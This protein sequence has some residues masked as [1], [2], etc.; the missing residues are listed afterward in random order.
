MMNKSIRT[1][2]LVAIACSFGFFSG[3]SC[4]ADPL[5]AVCG[6]GEVQDGEQCDD[7]NNDDG[8]SCDSDCT[9]P[10]DSECGN[11]EIEGDEQCDDGNTEGGDGC[12][13]NCETEG[14]GPVC[15]D[16]VVEGD[17]QCDDGN[18]IIY[19]GCEPDC[20]P[21]PDEVDCNELAPLGS[22]TCEVTAGS[23]AKLISGDVLLT[24]TILRGGQV[25]IGSDGILECVGCDCSDVG[26]GA[27]AIVCPQ[28]VV[29]PGLINSHDH[30]TFT[31]NAPYTDTGE[32]YEHRHDW[33]RGLNG[34]T[35]IDSSGGASDNQIRWGELRFLVGCATSNLRNRSRSWHG[36]RESQRLLNRRLRELERPCIHGVELL[37]DHLLRMASAHEL[38]AQFH[39]R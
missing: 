11:G 16:G 27:T 2:A 34:H 3:C 29:S 39:V 19:D 5:D 24:H 38:P 14:E 4:D 36:A 15:G 20:T 35:E 18:A 37:V 23:A 1:L 32:R 7:G 33:R 10:S 30:I 17:E 26:A 13:A 8:D 6:D 12:S 21:S 22:G 28:A 31:Q 25:L 9:T